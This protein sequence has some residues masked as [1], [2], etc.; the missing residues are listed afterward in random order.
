MGIDHRQAEVVQTYPHDGASFTQGLELRDGM[1]YESGGGFGNSFISVSTLDNPATAVNKVP[2][3]QDRF[4]EGLTVVGD[5]IW[6]ITWQNQ[7]ALLRDRASLAVE[8]EVAYTGEG[9][10]ICYQE[11]SK[12]LVMSDG[13][14]TLTLRDPQT[15]EVIR[16]VEVKEGGK[17]LEKLNELECRGGRVW[18]NV[19]Y[20]NDLVRIDLERGEVDMVVRV[21]ELPDSPRGVLNGVAALPGTDDLLIT[22]KNWEHLYRIRTDKPAAQTP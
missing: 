20:R 21:G 13:T 10:G 22:G 11:E 18:A 1:L 12:R 4:A 19:W 15:F 5:K 8:R 6:Q 2:L 17:A 16:K 9:W 14:A 7:V 3:A